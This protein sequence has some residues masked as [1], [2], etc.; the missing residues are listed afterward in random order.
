ML[1]NSSLRTASFLAGAFF[2]GSVSAQHEEVHAASPV[3][4][5]VVHA[6]ESDSEDPE[7]IAHEAAKGFNAGE[8]IMEHIGDSHSWHIV[9]HTSLPLPVILWTDKGLE[10]FSSRERLRPACMLRRRPPCRPRQ[11]GCQPKEE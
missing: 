2:M 1:L 6:L 8:L 11:S 4:S 10:C 3:D 9:G 7:A 5:A